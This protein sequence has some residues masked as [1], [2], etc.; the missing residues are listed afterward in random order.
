M[1]ILIISSNY[2]P[3]PVGIGL[4]TTDLAHLL[5]RDGVE[6]TVL[7]TFPYYPWWKTPEH[8]ENYAVEHAKINNI[9]VYRSQLKFSASYN[10]FSRIIFELRMWRGMKKVY[11]RIENKNFD[12]VIAVI[13]SLG[14]GFIARQ[15]VSSLKVPHYLIIQDIT[16]NGVSESG[17]SLGSLL[18]QIILPIERIVIRSANFI[19]VISSSMIEP[20][21]VM[22][23][24][25]SSISLLPNYEIEAPEGLNSLTRAD[26]KLPLD[27]F[28]V[29][30][31]GSIAQKQ[32]LENLVK[33][34]RLL[35]G[36]DVVFFL[37][38]HGNA[39]KAI[40]LAS[41]DLTNFSI[42]P[43]VPREQFLS[44]LR[45][46]NLLIVNE[47]ST[48]VS[49]ALPSKLI[50]YFSSGVPVIAAVPNSGATHRAIEGLAFW[51]DSDEPEL[52]AAAIK[53]IIL[54][55]ESRR[56]FSDAAL[57]FFNQ[58][59]RSEKGRERMLAWINSS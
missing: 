26:F 38:G 37:F 55:K 31:A 35:Q 54:S 24:Q 11:R 56:D 39:E 30:H 42:R 46:A 58:H 22:S 27:K 29:L 43:P 21:R 20:V 2:F 3:E 10:S 59:L 15:V 9:N 33:T 6:V 7:T 57:Q 25:S 41:Q 51:V 53:K 8:L 4:Y 12:K 18:R 32:G 44:L 1:R 19:A 13:P 45:C 17:M 23:R 5:N 36:T 40:S 50:S 28:V 47:R 48:Q 52:L 14:A 34:A 16:S 49:M